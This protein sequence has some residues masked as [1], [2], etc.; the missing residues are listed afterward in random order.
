MFV[1]KCQWKRRKFK[2]V[3]NSVDE[4][5]G[6]QASGMN[7]VLHYQL[8]SITKEEEEEEDDDDDDDDDDNRPIEVAPLPQ[9]FGQIEENHKGTK[10]YSNN[11][12]IHDW[13][14]D[15][16]KLTCAMLGR[17]RCAEASFY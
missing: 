4:V 6:Q 12:I 7:N 1:T 14:K 10:Y 15:K 17:T 9:M 13:M 8:S 2:E 16:K 3:Q 11:K 5:Q